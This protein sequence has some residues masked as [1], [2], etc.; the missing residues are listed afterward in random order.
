M[1]ND[2]GWRNDENKAPRTA[3][4]SSVA[5]NAARFLEGHWSFLGP[6][7]EE[8]YRTHTNKPEHLWNQV[9]E[10]MMLNFR[11]SGHVQGTIA[12]ARGTLKKQRRWKIVDTLLRW[13]S[14]SSVIVPHHFSVSLF[15]IYG[16]VSDSCEE[17]AQQISDHSSINTGKLVAEMN[18]GSESQVAPT[19]VS[20]LSNSF[21]AM[22]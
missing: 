17:L 3:N 9:A 7:T 5:T 22:F 20:V 11:E 4:S 18:E 1:H 6:G 2:I 15:S 13:F 19:V 12:L 8:Q 10:L 14:D 16:A 21:L